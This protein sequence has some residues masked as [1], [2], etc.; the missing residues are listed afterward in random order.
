MAIW[1]RPRWWPTSSPVADQPAARGSSTSSPAARSSG[2][3]SCMQTLPRPGVECNPS[4]F[5]RACSSTVS[6]ILERMPAPA[7]SK[8]RPVTPLPHGHAP[9]GCRSN[10]SIDRWRVASG[11][12]FALASPKGPPRCQRHG[13]TSRPTTTGWR[14]DPGSRSDC[15]ARHRRRSSPTMP[16]LTGAG[17]LVQG[18]S[19]GADKFIEEL[20][21]G[22]DF[23]A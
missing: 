18:G 13:T 23:I 1:A 2:I 7:T 16:E 19:P 5:G 21:S 9:R 22:V 12:Q 4:Q 17:I 14:D 10:H 8:G 3:H 6:V 20:D 11:A 15:Q